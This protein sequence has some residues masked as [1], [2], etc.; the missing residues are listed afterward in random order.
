M[1]KAAAKAR[2]SELKS[3]LEKYSYEYHVQDNPSVSDAIYDSLFNELKRLEGSYPELVTS[4][5]PTQRVGNVPLS[6]FKKVSHTSRL[7]SLNDVF[8]RQD[9]E[10][11]VE[12]IQKLLPEDNN[13]FFADLKMDGLSCALTYV[14]GVF[15]QAITRGDGFVGE[16]VTSN[17]RTIPS[18]PLRLRHTEE[19]PSLLQGRT[20]IRGEIIMLKHDF[21]E[22]NK[23]RQAAGL[24]VF[25]NPRN[26]ASGTIRQ[27][28]PRLVADRPLQFRAF[29]ILRDDMEQL[30]TWDSTYQA[31]RAIG[32]I[33]NGQAR[34]C[35]SIDEVMQFVDEW[36]RSRHRLP[37][38]TDGLVIKIN[39]RSRYEQLGVVGKNP[40]GAV[41]YKYPSEEATTVVKD[42]I[43]SIGRT[44]AATPVAVFSPVTVAGTTVQHA[45]LHN[46]DEISRKDIRVGDTVV[47]Y[48]AGDIIPQVQRVIFELRPS[49]AKAYNI[50]KELATQYPDLDF[51]RRDGEAIYRIKGVTGPLLLK[52]ALRHFAG[53]A[54]LDISTLGEKNVD[55]LVD[56]GLVKD[57]ADLYTLTENQVSK[58]DRFAETSARN[59]VAAIQAKKH[60][61]LARFIF[62]LG[63]R[64]VGQQTAVDLAKHFKRFDSLGS[65][66]LD[67]LREIDGIGEIV[68]ESIMLWFDDVDNQDLLTKLR[69]IGVWPKDLKSIGGKLSGTKFVITG[70]LQSMG[71]DL[72]A[73]KIRALGGTLQTVLGRDTDVLVVGQKVGKRKLAKA[74]EYG[75]KKISER[76]LLA[77][78]DNLQ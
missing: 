69:K 53:K 73:E 21:E 13:E 48:K 71:R 41:A 14:D 19:Y 7:L 50:E 54:A 35:K 1:T 68:A 37:F 74:T 29:D 45:S 5:S 78:L 16:D 28:D 23:R 57:I 26:L 59:L 6:K 70:T 66:T 72:A 63:I 64:H 33:A 61:E 32:V 55:T 17:V 24:T 47:V 3:L 8:S 40:R 65:A 18:V 60:P 58:L 34:V 9:V 22:L 51:V 30:P 46:A 52:R 56:S 10:D 62:A 27:L 67:K 4:D 2:I 43:L 42:I 49:S 36:E 39:N 76:D 12:R 75:T 77:M 44:G 15:K 38:I 20:E 25:A 31:S 11:W